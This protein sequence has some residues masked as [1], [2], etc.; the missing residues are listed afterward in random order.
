MGGGGG[1]YQTKF[2]RKT[3]VFRKVSNG[4]LLNFEVS[5]CTVR[6]EIELVLNTP[7][8]LDSDP[9]QTEMLDPQETKTTN[10]DINGRLDA[11]SGFSNSCPPWFRTKSTYVT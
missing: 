8:F 5:Q 9:Q 11:K 3:L 10:P 4:R 2:Y 1:G 6:S 7:S